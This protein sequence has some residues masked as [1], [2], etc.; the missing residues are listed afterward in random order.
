MLRLAKK[1]PVNGADGTTNDP[2]RR[3]SYR[4]SCGVTL[5]C[6]SNYFRQRPATGNGFELRVGQDLGSDLF[7]MLQHRHLLFREQYDWLS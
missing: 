4:T 7:G 1:E 5:F 3:T 2:S 6:G